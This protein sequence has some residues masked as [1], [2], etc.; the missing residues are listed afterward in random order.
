MITTFWPCKTETN[1]NL[2]TGKKLPSTVPIPMIAPVLFIHNSFTLTKR[3]GI[4][5][6]KCLTA[7]KK[8]H[9]FFHSTMKEPQLCVSVYRAKVFR[10]FY[11]IW[12]VEKKDAKSF[13]EFQFWIRWRKKKEKYKMLSW[14]LCALN[15]PRIQ[16][17]PSW[18]T[19]DETQI[20]GIMAMD[21]FI[22]FNTLLYSCDTF[23]I[24]IWVKK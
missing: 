23:C 7:G 16:L 4:E 21:V 2:H 1:A 20:F 6:E 5:T 18:N 12:L 19:M 15:G 13:N 3:N 10:I 22:Q 17:D 14:M 9:K 24:A 11:C 8:I